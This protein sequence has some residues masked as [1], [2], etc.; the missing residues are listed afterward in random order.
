[1]ATI[2][3]GALQLYAV[4]LIDDM[5]VSAP[6]CHDIMPPYLHEG[7]IEL[8]DRMSINAVNSFVFNSS[9]D[10]NAGIDGIPLWVK[11]ES[12]CITTKS[13]N[14]YFGTVQLHAIT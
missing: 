13:L 6:S 1:M 10:V 12:T 14:F 2:I 3:V 8:H 5:R 11:S 9:Q 4:E 7:S